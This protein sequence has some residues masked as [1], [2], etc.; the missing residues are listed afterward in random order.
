LSCFRPRGALGYDDSGVLKEHQNLLF[1]PGAAV[2]FRAVGGN[3]ID[4]SSAD[5]AGV[6]IAFGVSAVEQEAADAGG[7][8]LP[9]RR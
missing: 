1:S 3:G 4:G 7:A 2:C 9:Q 8:D 5:A 6:F